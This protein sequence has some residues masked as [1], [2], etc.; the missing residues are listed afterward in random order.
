MHHPLQVKL[1]RFYFWLVSH[2]APRLAVYS[3][4]RLF[5]Y[6]INS[7][8]KNRNALALP[9]P[10][11][12]SIPLYDGVKL[13][14]YR[15]GEAQHPK[16][17]LV[18]GWSTTSQSMTHFTDTL[19]YHNYQVISYDALRHGDSH[20]SFSD[21]ASWADSVRAAMA[22]VGEVECIIAHSFGGAAVTVASKLGLDTKKL[23]LI[24]PIHNIA[25]V[26]DN[27]ARHLGIPLHI[28]KEM[29]S[30]TW[31]H[32]KTNFEKYGKDWDDIVT[33][34]FHV[35]TLIY[36]DTEDKEIPILH[37][38]LLCKKW[39]W[40]EL[41]PTH[42]LGHRTILDDDAVAE[43]VLKFIQTGQTD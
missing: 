24:A 34:D 11:L 30:Y 23:V 10:E 22:H 42:G 2:I 3:A 1:I 29:R 6:P 35:P 26:A 18:H 43:G 31:N 36:H 41:H 38:K 27:F 19:L 39:T 32:N 16:V 4:H 8:R 14:G 25:S 7:K 13:Q 20:G 9:S 12:F 37:S 21:L 5:H 40:A 15:W 33:S 28:S 17:L